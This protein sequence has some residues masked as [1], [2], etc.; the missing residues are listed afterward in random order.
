M[1]RSPVAWLF[2]GWNCVAT[3]VPRPTMAV[4]SPP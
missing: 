3:T 1:I 4:T 2:S